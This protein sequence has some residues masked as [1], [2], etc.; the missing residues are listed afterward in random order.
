MDCLPP[1]ALES[2]VN[3]AG[4]EQHVFTYMVTVK[5]VLYRLDVSLGDVNP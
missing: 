4:E 2:G 5:G 3:F 1:V